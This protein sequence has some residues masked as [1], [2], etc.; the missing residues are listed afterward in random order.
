MMRYDAKLGVFVLVL[1]LL[2]LFLPAIVSATRPQTGCCVTNSS[3]TCIMTETSSCSSIGVFYPGRDCSDIDNCSTVCCV[4]LGSCGLSTQ[5]A[6]MLSNGNYSNEYKSDPDCQNFCKGNVKLEGYVFYHDGIPAS[7]ANVNIHDINAGVGVYSILSTNNQGYYSLMVNK[8]TNY[9]VNATASGTP[10]CTVQN[11]ILTTSSIGPYE[12]NLTL[13][14]NSPSQNCITKWN[15]GPWQDTSG[16][17]GN[18]T[19]TDSGNCNPPTLNNIPLNY[20]PCVGATS[21]GDGK[22]ESPEECEPIIL[23]LARTCDYYFPNQNFVGT[24]TCTNECKYAANCLKCPTDLSGCT[25]QMFCTCNNSVCATTSLCAPVCD[26]NSK[27]NLTA[28]GIF[29]Y[30]QPLGNGFGKGIQLDWQ[31][32]TPCQVSTIDIF[33]CVADDPIHPTKCKASTSPRRIPQKVSGATFTWSD[34]TGSLDNTGKT[35]YCYNI[36]VSITDPLNQLLKIGPDKLA[37][38]TIWDDKCIGIGDMKGNGKI[39]VGNNLTECIDGKI[40]TTNPCDCGCIAPTVLGGDARCDDKTTNSEKCD[41]CAVCSGPFGVMPYINYEL[42]SLPGYIS[43]YQ[44]CADALAGVD[45]EYKGGECFADDFAKNNTDTIGSIIGKYHAC[46]EIQT[47]YDYRTKTSCESNPCDTLAANDCEWMNLSNNDELGIGVCIPKNPDLQECSKCNDLHI[48]GDYCPESLCNLFGQNSSGQSTCFYNSIINY[49]HVK[50][51]N[52]SCINQRDVACETYDSK[53]QCVGNMNFTENVTYDNTNL[54]RVGLDNSIITLSNDTLKRGKCVCLDEKQRCIRNAD[55]T[56]LSEAVKSV[57]GDSCSDKQDKMQYCLDFENPNT[58]LRFND[59]VVKDGESY[60]V[61]ELELLAPETSEQVVNTYVTMGGKDDLGDDARLNAPANLAPPENTYAFVYP[62][63]TDTLTQFKTSIVGKIAGKYRLY[64]YSKDIAMNLEVL[65]H[66]DFTL[67]PDLSSIL[68]NYTLSSAYDGGADMY[69]TNLTVNIIYDPAKTIICRVNLTNIH[70]ST[71]SFIEDA[72]KSTP[73]LIWNYNYLPDGEY[74]IHTVC[75]DDHLQSFTN[76]TYVEID[77]D[78]S[79]HNPKP[80]GETFRKGNVNISLETNASAACYYTTNHNAIIAPITIVPDST[81]WTKYNDSS[82]GIKHSAT[83]NETVQMMRFFYSACNF[84]A[85]AGSTPVWYIGN[86]GDIIYYAIDET[87]PTVTLYDV[88]TGDVY[89]SSIATASVNIK[90]VCSDYSSNLETGSRNYSF[91]CKNSMNVTEYYRNVS[92]GDIV[93][94][95]PIETV[96]DGDEKVYDAPNIYVKV[97]LNITVGD[98]GVPSNIGSQQ[99][100]LNIRNLNFSQPEVTICDPIT[101]R[102]T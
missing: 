95:L 80:R 3:G 49:N 16:I 57:P 50:F 25:N 18:R 69:L 92:T 83:I 66:I 22:L 36:S 72:T 54:V 86:G 70:D 94:L 51:D 47:C 79:I 64:Y 62:K 102:C 89:N 73:N 74:N 24:V 4:L 33:R 27:V 32:P 84:N 42:D 77:A 34:F 30:P 68:V 85:T 82:N 78:K 48:L 37:C 98:K 21:C 91:G 40:T 56:P 8:N 96:A 97:Y 93:Q 71:L 19:V 44:F 35:A 45:T 53:N 7:S 9:L 10:S 29:D 2:L 39:C 61:A 65:K 17:C 5:G 28:K 99:K 26:N 1:G 41:I 55:F 20:T 59:Q 23:P 43:P 101:G 31:L 75:T 76:N 12:L 67:L 90:F 81:I 13:P 46:T 88:A 60:S 63:E 14:C 87:A 100:L 38:A 52:S 58:T 15:V 11:S 6:C